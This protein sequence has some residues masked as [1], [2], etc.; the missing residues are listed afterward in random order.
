[1]QDFENTFFRLWTMDNE[2]SFHHWVHESIIINHV[3][4]HYKIN[5]SRLKKGKLEGPELAFL[6]HLLKID[7]V[8]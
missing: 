3:F 5:S 2:S 1:M 6:L 4:N 7:V 8:I